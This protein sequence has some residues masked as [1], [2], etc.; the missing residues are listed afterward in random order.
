MR[1]EPRE[2]FAWWDTPAVLRRLEAAAPG[3]RLVPAARGF[4]LVTG[5]GR[6]RA[7]VRLPAIL[8]LPEGATEGESADAVIARAEQPR[9]R[10]LVLLVRAGAASLGLW[11][12]GDLAAHKVFKRYVVRGNGRAQ[13][14]YLKTKGK[15]RYGSRLRLQNAER[16][17]DE[18]VERVAEW[19]A[20]DGGFDAAFV[21]CPIRTWAELGP[22]LSLA[23]VRIP[24]HV[25]EPDHAE[26]LRVRWELERGVVDWVEAP[27]VR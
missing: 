24:F 11:V 21:S 3:A 9:G 15:S 14:A 16:L 10:D 25:H 22:R 5:D 8:A 20:E 27:S 17:L 7:S 23:P 26:L 6:T 4:A 18:V 19:Q 12:G 2:R 1:M 13:P